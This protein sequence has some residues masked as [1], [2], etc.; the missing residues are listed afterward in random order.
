MRFT[1]RM[2][3]VMVAGLAVVASSLATTIAAASDYR[4]GGSSDLSVEVAEEGPRW[5]GE[6]P[7]YVD[8]LVTKLGAY[9]DSY[10]RQLGGV[11]LS[12]DSQCAILYVVAA[13]RSKLPFGLTQLISDNED[14]IRVVEVEYSYAELLEIRDEYAQDVP[15][16]FVSSAVDIVGNKVVLGVQ[17]NS[18]AKVHFDSLQ[19]VRS[20]SQSLIDVE[21]IEMA[22]DA[23]GRYNDYPR[24]Y[25]GGSVTRSGAVCSLGI[26]VVTGGIRGVLTA[27]HC[28]VGT[29]KTPR[30]KFVGSTL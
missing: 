21:E 18:P 16:G 5:Q 29:F 25:M 7:A 30:G 28:G 13:E 27:G 3:A 11:A 19:R 2:W 14:L 17:A 10:P 23:T 26:P 20:Y 12:P 15:S 9:V 6:T 24:Y 1:R 8:A 4:G 22:E